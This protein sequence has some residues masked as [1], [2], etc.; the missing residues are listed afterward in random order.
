MFSSFK[1]RRP[2]AVVVINLVFGPFLGMLYLGRAKIAFTYLGLGFALVGLVIFL[3]PLPIFSASLGWWLFEIP[4]NVVG[5]THGVYLARKRSGTEPLPRYA[6]WYSLVGIN[7]AFLLMAFALR[8]FLYQPFSIPSAAMEPSLNI[9]DYFFASKRAYDNV[10]PQRG[11]IVV[12]KMPNPDS[13]YYMRDFV[14]RVI[15]LP[16]DRIQMLNG[17]IYINSNAVPKVRAEDYVGAD[18]DGIVR[19][20]ARYREV[21]PNGKS[22]YVLDAIQSGNEDNT[23]VFTVPAG[24][25]FVM[26]DNRDDSDDSRLSVGYVPA[27]DLVGK[28]V[29]KFVDG[30]HET[31]IWERID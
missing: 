27:E 31:I 16:G 1:E 7:L 25:Y 28:A 29:A 6:R 19:P 18:M 21:L 3:V 14:K 9:G 30:Q 11:D 15:G 12:F 22:Y 4:L 23:P 10:A 24:H 8:T 20:I 17:V 2:W 26:G 13:A 5:A